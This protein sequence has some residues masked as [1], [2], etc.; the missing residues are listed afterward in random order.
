MRIIMFG[1]KLSS[2]A[3]NFGKKLN[4]TAQRFGRKISNTVDKVDAGIERGL[5]EAQDF[6]G[7]VARTSDLVNRRIQKSGSLISDI[8]LGGGTVIGSAIGQPELGV[9]ASGA[10]N[11]GLR[12]SDRANRRIKK[13]SMRFDGEVDNIRMKHNL[14]RK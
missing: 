6:S 8:A 1:R 10:I 14:E 2:R 5:N 9:L 11:Q 7:K 4:K 3:Q 13:G 12:A